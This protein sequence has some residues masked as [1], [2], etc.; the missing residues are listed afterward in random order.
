MFKIVE[1]RGIWFMISSLAILPGVI[2]MIWSFATTGQPLPLSIDYTG[3][4]L[5]EMRFPQ[6]V[7]SSQVRQVFVEA[8]YSDTTV[9]HVEDDFTVQAKLKTIDNDQKE[10]LAESLRARLGEFEELSYRSIGPAIGGEV[11]R[12]AI[13]A[14]AIAAALV[15]LYIAIA[16][17]QVSHPFR[18]GACAVVALVHDVLVTVSFLAIMN[19]LVGWEV[20]ALFLTAI[21]TVIGYSVNDT[22]VVFD[23][24]REN[25]KRYRGEPMATIANR[26]I[27]ETVQRSLATQTTT[28][29]SLVA[30]LALGGPTVRQFMAILVVGIASGMFSSIFNAA[31]L[32]VAWEERSLVHR[33]PT[34]GVSVDARAPSVRALA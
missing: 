16:F 10:T 3:G 13:I 11:S 23:R 9:F 24:I 2:Y 33:Q 27:V 25:F 30:I 26:S 14:V 4:T 5:W 8:G 31:A 6:A 18:F 19:L 29:L 1:R 21:L 20:D 28:L 32:L 22:I 34:A 7:E 12:A 17:R 15:L